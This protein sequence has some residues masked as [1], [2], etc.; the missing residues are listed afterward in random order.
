MDRKGRLRR[1]L[2]LVCAVLAS[3]AWPASSVA[4]EGSRPQPP[5]G[6]VLPPAEI[7][8]LFDAYTGMQAQEALGLDD[9]QFA[10]FLP[11]LRAL[12]GV[13]R[14]LD[15]ERQRLTADLAR[16]IG[17]AR[18]GDDRIREQLRALAELDTRGAADVRA[19]YEALDETLDLQRSARFRVFEFQMERRKFE[20]LTRARR[21]DGARVPRDDRR[22]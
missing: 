8:R 6:R 11:R 10:R 1:G 17:P 19:A 22:N 15:V 12:Q 14:R 16:L 21:G 3:L 4:Q 7:H 13:R 2:W 20:L 9:T 18:A 5:A